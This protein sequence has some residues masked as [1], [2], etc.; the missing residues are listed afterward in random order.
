MTAADTEPP[1]RRRTRARGFP[2]VPLD[3]AADV[4]RRAGRYGHSHPEQ[5]FAGYL[6]HQT[7]NS[8]AFKQRFAAMRSWGLVS[9]ERNEV[10]LTD[11]GR[12]LAHPIS[13]EDERQAMREAF[14]H[15]AVFAELYSASAKGHELDTQILAN[16]AVHSL[17]ISPKSTT[18]FGDVFARSAIAAGLAI[19]LAPGKVEL[20]GDEQDQDPAPSAS[21]SEPKPSL[22][23]QEVSTGT[24]STSRRPHSESAPII[25]Q[26]WPAEGGSI[27]FEVR[28]DQPLPAKA[29]TELAGIFAA[30]ERLV[31]ELGSDVR[32]SD[33]DD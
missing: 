27:S 4:I 11:L 9:A 3:E 22:R 18:K 10:R 2:V 23:E 5:A 12:R 25:H 1:D 17:G 24:P 16:R 19:E 21:E 13:P 32:P 31:S 28:L 14:L 6:G 33:E 7:T 15:A 20:I 26:V 30:V 29:F 8:G